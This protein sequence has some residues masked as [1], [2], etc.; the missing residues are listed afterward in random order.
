MLCFLRRACPCLPSTS[1][2]RHDESPT[3]VNVGWYP[4]VASCDMLG[5]RPH[6][7]I[8]GEA[9]QNLMQVRFIV[10]LHLEVEMPHHQY[11]LQLNEIEKGGP[12]V[13]LDT[14]TSVVVGLALGDVRLYLMDRN[15]KRDTIQDM[16]DIH[17]V[18]PAYIRK[19]F[20]LYA[21]YL[22]RYR[23]V[24]LTVNASWLAGWLV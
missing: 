2:F 23:F 10:T 13:S 8:P 1:V 17:V 6:Y 7:S 11:Y 16:S 3:L 12:F 4:K 5:E 9:L 18:E 14:D 22:Q 24:F 21:T 15:L 19:W 20:L